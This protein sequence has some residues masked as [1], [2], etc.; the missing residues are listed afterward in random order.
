VTAPPPTPLLLLHGFSGCGR[1]WGDRILSALA[2][3]RRV[4]APDL[5]GHGGNRTP[6]DAVHFTIQGVVDNLVRELDDL[7]IEQADWVGYS[8]GGRVAL[9]AAVLRPDRVRHLVLE[10]AS[11]GIA[12][13]AAREERKAQDWEL[14]TRIEREGGAWFADYWE[15]RPLFTSRRSLPDTV[16]EE[17]RAVRLAQD[18]A[19]L[20]AALR[21]FGTGEQPSWWADLP[22]VDHPTLLLTGSLDTKFTSLAREMATALPQAVHRVV[23][24]A[25]HTVHLEAEGEWHESVRGWTGSACAGEE[26]LQGSG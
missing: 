20:A 8:M 21:G 6:R 1:S 3:D 13:P 18:P 17:M 14:A 25:G 4:L 2:V 24:G 23:P 22:G 7:G 19:G 10:S 5:P 12:D 15:A 16:R 9:A 11:P 26:G